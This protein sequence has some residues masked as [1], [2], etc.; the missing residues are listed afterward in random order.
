A[1]AQCQNSLKQLGLAFHN[2]HQDHDRF[3]PGCSSRHNVVTYLLPYLGET[4]TAARYDFGRDWDSRA[5]NA[6]GTTNA[7]AGRHDIRILV[8]PSAP[9]DRAGQAVSDYVTANVIYAP[10]LNL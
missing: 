10:A 4:A 8:C 2:Y 3:P 5:P 6:S 9:N 7:E 1:R